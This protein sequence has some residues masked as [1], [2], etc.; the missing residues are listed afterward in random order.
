MMMK[1]DPINYRGAWK[2]LRY[3][4]KKRVG[5]SQNLSRGA[6]LLATQ[7][8]DTYANS[9]TGCC[10]PSDQ[11][12]A[13]LFRVSTRTIQRWVLE[14]LKNGWVKNVRLNCRRRALQ[15]VFPNTAEDDNKRDKSSVAKTTN[16]PSGPDTRVASHKEPKKNLGKGSDGG[17]TG[18]I[19]KTI[20]VTP[21]EIGS[22]Q[23][24]ADWIDL[25]LDSPAE[26]VLQSVKCGSGFLLPC[27]FPSNQPSFR[28]SYLAYFE[29]SI[30]S[31]GP[32]FG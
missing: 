1:P 20:I 6:K 24:W 7:L 13:E 2:T 15:L 8:C 22:L 26:T 3:D 25:N 14:L 29:A 19:L 10:W 31:R 32:D 4:W 5:R 28:E 9:S 30:R 11:T 27:R 18:E 21:R 17:G 23:A 16:L 12:L